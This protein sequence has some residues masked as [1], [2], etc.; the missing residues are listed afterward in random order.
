MDKNKMGKKTK[1]EYH[2]LVGKIVYNI[3][4]GSR[5]WRRDFV[6][7]GIKTEAM[8]LIEASRQQLHLVID[9]LYDTS[10]PLSVRSEFTAEELTML[11][12]GIRARIKKLQQSWN[13][14]ARNV[15]LE[16]E[17]KVTNRMEFRRQEILKYEALQL[18][19]KELIM[20]ELKTDSDGKD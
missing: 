10:T 8:I 11:E 12:S 17:E 19:M 14:D 2:R 15:D 5:E 1:E 7:A 18:R 13:N 4:S 6:K 9:E 3:E 16:T 20:I